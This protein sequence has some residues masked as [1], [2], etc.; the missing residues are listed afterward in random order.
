MQ[1]LANYVRGLLDGPAVGAAFC[2]LF[3][4][5][6]C[7]HSQFLAFTQVSSDTGVGGGGQLATP[8]LYSSEKES[9]E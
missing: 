4:H 2:A 8:G 7:P 3:P 6:R 1:L 9:R 5:R